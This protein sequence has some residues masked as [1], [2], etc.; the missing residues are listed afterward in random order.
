MLY[1]SGLLVL[2]SSY[3]AGSIFAKNTKSDIGII[4]ITLI[5]FAQMVLS[6]EILSLLNSIGASGFLI[7]NVISFI[8]SLIAFCKLKATIYKPN[9]IEELKNINKALKRDKIL[10]F[11]SVLFVLFLFFK[12]FE[13]L[14]FPITFGDALGY[15]LP[16]CTSWIQNGNISH[17]ITPD[18]RELIMPVNME[19]LYTWIFLFTKSEQGMGI[20][21]YISFLGA[22]LIIYNLL[23]EL[24][25]CRRKRIWS[26]FVFSSFIIISLMSATPC[27]DLFIGSLL[28]TAI[29][30]FY[31]FIKYENKP[32]LYF[33]TLAT[34]LA[35]GTKTTA[36]IAFPSVFAIIL[37]LTW[38]NKKQILKRTIFSY[39]ALLF[40]NFVIFSSYNYILNFLQFSN[41]ISCNEQFLI[42]QFRGGIKGYL[43][44]I[45]KYFVCIFD[46][47][48]INLPI[49]HDLINNLQVKLLALVGETPKSYSSARFEGFFTFNGGYGIVNAV[50][51]AMGLFA[52]LPALIKGCTKK[53]EKRKFLLTLLSFSFIF[54]VLLFSRVMVF[55]CYNLRYLVTFFVIA[56]PIVVFSYIKSNKNL[57]KWIMTYLMFVYL[58]MIPHQK[59]TTFLFMY[60]KA[61]DKTKIINITN[62]EKIIY[63]YF[64][65]KEP[66]TIALMIYNKEIVLSYIEELKLHGFK[67]DKILA[68]NYESYDLSKYDYIIANEYK[69]ASTNVQSFGKKHCLYLD[70][71]K[72]TVTENNK[73]IIASVECIVPFAYFYQNGF[74]PV[75][76][77]DLIE[78]VILK[79]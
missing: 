56:S 72:E 21:S 15:Y 12:L 6:F 37:I 43:T 69:I 65:K 22:I 44:N 49:Y 57:F 58:F 60:L 36:I 30:L 27:A 79:K 77:I 53:L 19:F 31:C 51:G 3:L 76:D 52:F 54:N 61:K 25:F 42:N 48:G 33:S 45:I 32:L 70:K 28:L 9:F 13:V 68:E 35:I 16:R 46:F 26:A 14:V 17:F 40:I 11:I 34:A 38:Q 5:A 67:T 74:K 24:G 1:I 64:M 39:C 78:Y 71:D 4:Y 63:Q 2:V 41:P 75:K 55:T 8:V 23:G 20:F 29:Y 10:K 18:T 50:L 62:Q 47:S 73:K 59:P 66:T 7:C